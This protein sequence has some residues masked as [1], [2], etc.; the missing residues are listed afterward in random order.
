MLLGI[1]P[2]HSPLPL[3]HIENFNEFLGMGDIRQ[4]LENFLKW[5][6][7]YGNSRNVQAN[8]ILC[9]IHLKVKH[10]IYKKEGMMGKIAR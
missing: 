2:K 5:G 8:I 4:L 1:F 7:V 10:L 9:V 3:L 6:Y